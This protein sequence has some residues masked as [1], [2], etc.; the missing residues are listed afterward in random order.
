MT[1]FIRDAHKGVGLFLF[2][3]SYFRLIFVDWRCNRWCGCCSTS[4]AL[5][6]KVESDINEV[7][8]AFK[9]I[10]GKVPTKFKV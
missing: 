10:P 7:Y 2:Y 1:R 5:N 9:Q 3:L 6:F 4:L 8:S